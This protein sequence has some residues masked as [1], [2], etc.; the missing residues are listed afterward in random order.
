MTPKT[1]TTDGLSVSYLEANPGAEKTIFFIHGNS[2]T[3]RMWKKQLT[4]TDL[5]DYRLIAFDLPG[6][7]QSDKFPLEKTYSLPAM[8]EVVAKAIVELSGEKEYIV[9][10]FSLGTNIVAETL[11]FDLKP[12][13]LVF[14]GSCLLGGEIAFSDVAHPDFDATVIFTDH[15]PKEQVDK[16]WI[17]ALPRSGAGEVRLFREDY[18][19][20]DP[21]FR[22]SVL[23]TA[24]SGTIANEI[25]L[26]QQYGRPTFFI[27]GREEASVNNNYLD[28]V[29]LPFWRDAPTIV[30]DA[31]HF[32]TF[33]QPR[34]F[35][36]LLAEYA[37]EVFK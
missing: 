36:R 7:G 35:N 1:L 22:P 34:I 17:N 3:A 20:A 13:G 28:N 19:K 37:D 18:D 27:F 25:E 6:H 31:G 9:A 30:P 16:F 29:P 23:Q 26:V 15:P 8:G 4:D 11:A 14:A 33:E 32:V 2:C 12:A 5:K 24:L 10:G 21:P